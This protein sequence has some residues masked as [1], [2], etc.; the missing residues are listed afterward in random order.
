MYKYIPISY[1][2]RTYFGLLNTDLKKKKLNYYNN[3]K[4]KNTKRSFIYFVWAVLNTIYY[5]S[6]E[7]I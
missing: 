3:D 4:K 2:N 5:F 1:N 6:T 7:I